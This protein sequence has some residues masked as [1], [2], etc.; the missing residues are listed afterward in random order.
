MRM[1][2]VTRET[3]AAPCTTPTWRQSRSGG[4]VGLFVAFVFYHLLMVL[5]PAQ[6]QE[7]EPTA[8]ATA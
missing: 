3:P 2:G 5:F 4:A 7:P 1:A 8:A 6:R